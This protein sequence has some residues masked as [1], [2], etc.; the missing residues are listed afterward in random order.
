[1]IRRLLLT[2]CL[3]LPAGAFADAQPVAEQLRDA[4]LADNAA[5]E[6]VSA[7]TTEIGPRLAGSEADARAVAWASAQLRALGFDAVW[8][9]AFTL[10]RWR[11]GPATAEVLGRYAQPLAITA[12]GSSVGTNGPLE[13]EVVEVADFAALQAIDDDRLRGKIVFVSRALARSRDGAD[14]GKAADAR[15]KGPIEAARRGAAAFLLRSLSTSNRR[16][17]HTGNTRLPTDVTPIPAA[18]LSVPD[19]E[20]LQRMLARGPVRLRL[21]IDAGSAGETVSHNVIGEIRGRDPDAGIVVIGAHLDSW[22]LGTGAVDDGAGIA[23]TMAAGAKIAALAQR[24][25]RTI[26]VIA[27]GAEEFG[28]IGAKAYARDNA[29]LIPLHSI[30]LESDFGAGRIYALRAGVSAAALPEFE[31]MANVL[32]PLGIAFEPGKGGPGPD[33]IPLADAGMPWAQLAQDG[34]DYFDLHHTADDTLDKIDPTALDQQVAAYAA[35]AW[36]L[37]ES[38]VDYR[39]APPR[40]RAPE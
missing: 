1:M 39:P 37:A 32:A 27:F 25:R 29:K 22:D 2:V 23:I 3:A 5:F 34:S 21:D 31:R 9:E 28:L 36:M 17:P 4:A 6:L 38:D 15:V 20:Q 24:P 16:L 14:Y 18:A 11:R 35:L 26:R 40:T 7:L 8:S 13:A 30:G 33:I 10:P 19:A 12:L